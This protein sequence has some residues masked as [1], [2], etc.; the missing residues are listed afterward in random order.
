MA[1]GCSRRARSRCGR[2]RVFEPKLD[3]WKG[4]QRLVPEDDGCDDA[5]FK[6]MFV[7]SARVPN[8][9]KAIARRHVTIVHRGC[10][11]LRIVRW[12][13]VNPEHDVFTL[14]DRDHNLVRQP[15]VDSRVDPRN[16]LCNAAAFVRQVVEP[17]HVGVGVGVKAVKN[18][19]RV[20]HLGNHVPNRVLR[21]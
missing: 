1:A 13:V 17:Q 19:V 20:V 5:A 3:G 15:V 14:A 10:Q 7:R 11:R 16:R 12:P 6:A 8:L 18:R 4:I 21:D 2:C 9:E